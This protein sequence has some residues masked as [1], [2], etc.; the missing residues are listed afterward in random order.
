MMDC[1]VYELQRAAYKTTKAVYPNG[2][3]SRD[4]GLVPTR[5]TAQAVRDLGTSFA[6]LRA[7][8]HGFTDS[9]FE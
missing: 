5:A 2:T 4:G 7:F 6:V 8:S 9:S 3:R 1:V